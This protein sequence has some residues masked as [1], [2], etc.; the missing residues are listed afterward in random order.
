MSG[1]TNA[2]EQAKP[3]AM[4]ALANRCNVSPD[5]VT[6]ALTK[7]VFKGAKPEELLALVVVANEYNLNPF[8]REIYAFPAKGGGIVPVVSIDGWLNIINSHPQYDGMDEEYA[9]D[10]SWCKVS[11]HRKDRAHPTVHT[12]FL[13][14]C[15]RNTEPW[16]QHTRRML[17]WKAI[18]QAG[19]IAFGFSGIQDEDEARETAG[20]KSAEDQESAELLNDQLDAAVTQ[21]ANET[22]PIDGE[23][24]E[25]TKEEKA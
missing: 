5:K 18:I 11:I 9:P 17:K 20:I 6:N 7:T 13:E 10:G 19:R 12:E 21:K 23:T 15:K 22:E 4:L 16:K 3:S 24:V 8:T 14:E 2:I 1:E 25:E